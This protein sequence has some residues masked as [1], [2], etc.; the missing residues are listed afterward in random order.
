MDVLAFTVLRHLEQIDDAQE[1]RLARQLASDIGEADWLN[2]TVYTAVEVRRVI[3]ID[4]PAIVREIHEWK[5]AFD[6]S[7][8][9]VPIRGKGRVPGDERKS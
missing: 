6:G 9:E 2:G 8:R 3:Q 7:V 4:D 5:R 1:S